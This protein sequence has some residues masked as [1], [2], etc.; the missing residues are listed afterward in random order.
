MNKKKKDLSGVENVEI[1]ALSE[2]DLQTVSAG[3]IGADIADDISIFSNAC[4]TISTARNACC[5]V[6]IAPDKPEPVG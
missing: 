3:R 6:I 2:E 5:P 4:C 1:E